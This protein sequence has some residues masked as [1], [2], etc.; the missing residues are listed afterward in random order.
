V[1]SKYTAIAKFGQP[2]C[3]VRLDFFVAKRYFCD[4]IGV[5]ESIV[6]ARSILPE[7][8]ELI[9]GKSYLSRG[10]ESDACGCGLKQS[11]VLSRF[12]NGT[13]VS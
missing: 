11:I 5:L 9:A 12:G 2:G 8:P 13:S 6:M 1:I 3:R 4:L 7:W 10:A